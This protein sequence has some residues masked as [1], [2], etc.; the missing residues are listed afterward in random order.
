MASLQLPLYS[1]VLCCNSGHPLDMLQQP[2]RK[3]FER[4]LQTLLLYPKR[5]AVVA[6]MAFPKA[7]SVWQTSENDL[8][9]IAQYY[10][11]PILSVRYVSSQLY[12]TL[13][14]SFLV[15]TVPLM[16]THSLDTFTPAPSLSCH[17]IRHVTALM[18]AQ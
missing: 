15:C 18:P 16:C 3:A 17:C 5:P 13:A 9:V 14:S 8:T 10:Q 4:V 6:Y 7:S 11:L 12:C 1:T 2:H